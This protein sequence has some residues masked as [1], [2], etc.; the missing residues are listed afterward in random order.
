M[1][2]SEAYV[3]GMEEAYRSFG[4]TAANLPTMFDPML[5]LKNRKGLKSGFSGFKGLGEKVKNFFGNPM[6]EASAKGGD[7][8]KLPN[9]S[10]LQDITGPGAPEFRDF[11]ERK[12]MEKL[13]NSPEKMGVPDPRSPSGSR[14]LDTE[15]N[16]SG[17]MGLRNKNIMGVRGRLDAAKDIFKDITKNNTDPLE[18]IQDRV[19]PTMVYHQKMDQFLKDYGG[20]ASSSSKKNIVDD[21][22]A[23]GLGKNEMKNFHPDILAHNK[24]IS[25]ADKALIEEAIKTKRLNLKGMAKDS[26]NEDVFHPPVETKDRVNGRRLLNLLNSEFGSSSK[27]QQEI[28]GSKARNFDSSLNKAETAAKYLRYGR[29]AAIG[30]VPIAAGAY[31]MNREGREK[32]AS[33]LNKMGLGAA[34]GAIAG[35]LSDD[36][37]SP[38]GFSS[39]ALMGAGLGAGAGGLVHFAPKLF[40]GLGRNPKDIPG[41]P[42]NALRNFSVDEVLKK[43]SVEEA[44]RN[45]AKKHGLDD[46]DPSGFDKNSSVRGDLIKRIGTGAALGGL[47][48]SILGGAAGN[49]VGGAGATTEEKKKEFTRNRILKGIQSGGLMGAVYGGALGGITHRPVRPSDLEDATKGS[50]DRMNETFSGID[51]AMKDLKRTIIKTPPKNPYKK[52]PGEN[53]ID[54]D[55]TK[56]SHEILVNYFNL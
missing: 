14:I 9:G 24:G 44:L 11:A 56:K 42:E 55:F 45:I 29:N 1:S 7:F 41:S 53:V 33:A 19:T 40:K 6:T 10:S 37:V 23:M 18:A 54:V 48:G 21:I 30:A 39:R 34:A 35:R 20:R 47:S 15:E 52:R 13:K 50:V 5:A 46:F 49:M 27:F 32:K 16:M 38:S 25:P 31:G 26:V 2:L 22:A 3:A 51:K 36:N 4:K 8:L 28:P 12:M 17:H 43:H